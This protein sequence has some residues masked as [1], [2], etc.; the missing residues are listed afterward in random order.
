[1]VFKEFGVLLHLLQYA[2]LLFVR[3]IQDIVALS[4]ENDVPIL[5]DICIRGLYVLINSPY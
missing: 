1:M 5:Q 3:E 4:L 2:L